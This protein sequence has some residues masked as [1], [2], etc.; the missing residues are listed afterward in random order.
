MEK[1]LIFL[2]ILVM[3][4]NGCAA[5]REFPEVVGKPLDTEISDTVVDTPE[6]TDVPVTDVQPPEFVQNQIAYT[7]SPTTVEEGSLVIKYEDATQSL[8]GITILFSTVNETG[9]NVSLGWVNSCQIEVTT[10]DGMYYYDP[11]MM[12]ISRG[13]GELTVE[14]KGASGAIQKIVIT[15]LC[16][17]SNHG[18]PDERINNVVVYDLDNNVQFFEGYFAQNI[19]EGS[20]VIKYEDALQSLNGMTILLSTVNETGHNVSLGWV[21]SCQIEVTTT[22]G[23]YYYDPFMMEIPRGVGELTVEVKGASGVIQKIV[24]TE[25]CL[26][27]NHGFPDERINNVVVY[28][29]DNNVQHFRGTFSDT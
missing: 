28:D 1:I 4:L 26:L 6:T 25:L 7:D 24:I 19:E 17:L 5:S 3:L 13:V 11:F 15:E 21:D 8:N 27:S 23:V 10:T 20:L 2:I 22:E 14:V 12:E 16:L 18:F 9:Y 29:F